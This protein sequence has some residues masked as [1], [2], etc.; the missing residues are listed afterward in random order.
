MLEEYIKQY[1]TAQK[2]GDKKEMRRIEN[3]L[4]R[5]GMDRATLI[6]LAREYR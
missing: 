6:V 3:D 1:V 5:L 4:R 2:G